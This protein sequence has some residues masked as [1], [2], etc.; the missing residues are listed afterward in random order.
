[1]RITLLGTGTS[2]GVP[3]IGC[4]CAVCH[5][6]DPHDRRL[7]PSILIETGR[8]DN[9][10]P[11]STNI[12]VDTSTDLRAQALAHDVRRVDA[13]LFTH[14]HADHV[15]GLDEVRRY[16]AMQRAAIPCYADEATLADLRRM[17]AYIFSSS[18]AIAGGIPQ[19]TANRIAGAFMLGGAEII[20]VPIYH[21]QRPILGFRIGAF[22]YL[23]D[24]S[25]IPDASW[26]LLAGVR[27]LVLDALR[28]RPHPTHFT[29]AEA[30]EAVARVAPERA[31]L[32]HI[33]HDLPHA[34]TCAR[35]P[36]GVELAYD[37]LVL[38]VA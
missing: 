21:G 11:G 6:T 5:S 36:A 17:F 29:V 3:A 23:T 20:P 25:R 7:R 28:D 31:Y 14:S 32:T 15:L 35:L 9:G 18:T 13:I 10:S 4:D 38:D 12:L 26:P 16:N 19:L 27:V 37:G 33:C 34:A 22:A 30:L 1:M 2:H 24:C 8:S